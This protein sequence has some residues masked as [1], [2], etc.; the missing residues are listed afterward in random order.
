MKNNNN[1]PDNYYYKNSTGIKTGYTSQAKNCL[2]AGSL[3]DGLE[4]ISVTLYG[5][6][7]SNGL[8]QRYLDT[9]NL[10]N[11]GYNNFNLKEIQVGYSSKKQ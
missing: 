6:I 5:G 7:N 11:Y 10:F 2:I 4:F 8:S 3:R 1:R 9:I